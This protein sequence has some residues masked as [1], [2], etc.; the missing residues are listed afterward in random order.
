MQVFHFI[1]SFFSNIIVRN[2]LLLGV[3]I[4]L[5]VG[6]LLYWLEDYT[7]HN[8]AIIVPDVNGLQVSDAAPMLMDQQL[9]YMVID[10]INSRTAAPGAIVDQV[11][12]ALSKVKQNRIVFLTINARNAQTVVLPNILELSQ[13]QALAKLRALGFQ[14]DSIEYV[15]YEY[16]DLVIDVLYNEQS[17]D[18]QARLPYGS[19]LWIQVGDGFELNQDSIQAA[20]DSIMQLRDSIATY[21]SMPETEVE[22]NDWFE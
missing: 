21:E 4:A 8:Q 11:P 1:K 6:G 13:R 15:P 5:L 22:S 10:S 16:K 19:S 7:R 12:K 14:I 18:S 3:L 9:R 20:Q 2:L 17:I